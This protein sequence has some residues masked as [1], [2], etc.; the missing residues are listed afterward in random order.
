MWTCVL[1]Q[2]CNLNIYLSGLVTTMMICTSDHAKGWEYT[3]SWRGR[4]RW[5]DELNTIFINTLMEI[6]LLLLLIAVVGIY[7][8]SVIRRHQRSEFTTRLC[9]SPYEVNDGRNLL[10][11][12]GLKGDLESMFLWQKFN[13]TKKQREQ[14]VCSIDF[15]IM[16]PAHQSDKSLNHL[17]WCAIIYMPPSRHSH[18]QIA[19]EK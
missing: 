12:V 13:I 4:R 10:Y 14:R 15:V 3:N 8:H 5:G 2:I 19:L 17:Y 11:A 6:L 7:L 16:M 9:P 18:S 1:Y